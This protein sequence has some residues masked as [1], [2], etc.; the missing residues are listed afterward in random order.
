MAA[1][2]TPHAARRL[3]GKPCATLQAVCNACH[4]LFG[5]AR[6]VSAETLEIYLEEH[7]PSC[8]IGG[9]YTPEWRH[10]R[11]VNTSYSPKLAGVEVTC[12]ELSTIR[13]GELSGFKPY[14]LSELRPWFPAL[15]GPIRAAE[16]LD[17]LATARDSVT[18]HTI[19]S[20]QSL[21]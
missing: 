21:R 17:A 14:K 12:A 1:Q 3:L 2:P 9:G 15:T 10:G 13:S 18:H 6:H 7:F 4:L 8:N 11:L 19:T 16:L 20:N 5:E